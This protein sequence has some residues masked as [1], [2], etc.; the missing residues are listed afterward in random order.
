[1]KR[2]IGILIQLLPIILMAWLCIQLAGIS[3]FAI[4]GI[5]PLTLAIVLGMMLGNT[6]PAQYMHYLSEGI[7]FSKSKLLRLGIIL[8]GLRM[9]L[10]QLFNVG[11]SALIT[12]I[13]VVCST[14]GLAILLGKQ[15]KLGHQMA[16]LIGAGSSICGAA[17]VLAAQPILN[18][19]EHDVGVAVATVVVFGT[20]AMFIYPL[21]ATII[22]PV[23]ST[24]ATWFGWGLYT[25]G[26]VH[27]VAQVAAAGAAVNSVVADVAV[28]TKMIRVM[29]LAP[30]LLVLPWLMR[31]FYKDIE[32]NDKNIIIPW[33][34]LGFLVMIGLNSVISIPS[35]LHHTLL[36][37]DTFLLTIAMFALGLTTHW[38]SVRRAGIK[39]LIMSGI[40]ALWLLLGGGIIS[41]MAYLLC[42]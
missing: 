28:I 12:D 1:M 35:L 29:L 4:N 23:H 6:I 20:I 17:A 13:L 40:L 16:A 27:E 34:A 37:F 31:Y 10:S 9:T 14:F 21:M 5:G 42:K 30:F 18:A 39:P 3:I 26:T 25:G 15:L 2:Y 22:L 24:V 32:K 41:Y 19:K 38:H 36:D 33:F 8:Y 7:Q 11:W